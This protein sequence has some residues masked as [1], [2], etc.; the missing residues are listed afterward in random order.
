MTVVAYDAAAGDDDN[1][2]D[3]AD[4]DDC[5][6]A[7]APYPAARKLFHQIEGTIKKM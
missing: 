2:D 3:D 6:R 1:D 4:V 7:D 5:G